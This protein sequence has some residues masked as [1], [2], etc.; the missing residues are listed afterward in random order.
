MPQ[1]KKA[2]IIG[3]GI[4]GLAA[5]IRLSV[6]GFEVV[7]YEKNAYPGGKLSHFSKDG[8][9]FDAGPSLFTQPANVQ[10]LFDLAKEPM[11]PYFSYQALPISFKYFYE[12]GVIINA[13]TN[14][15]LLADELANK[16]GEKKISHNQLFKGFK[17]S[18]RSYCY[19]FFKSFITQ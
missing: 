2:I 15:D 14:N 11:A 12:D 5:A 13:Y 9:R 8:Y 7:V 16:L 4:A 17:K 6:Q 18:I 3:S 19:C 1:A 10:E